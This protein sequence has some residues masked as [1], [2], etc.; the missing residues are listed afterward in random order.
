MDDLQIC[1]YEQIFELS[2]KLR[3]HLQQKM[4]LITKKLF[5]GIRF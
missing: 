4:A 1:D 2:L 5:A 3:H